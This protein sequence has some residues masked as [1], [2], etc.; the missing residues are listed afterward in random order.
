MSLSAGMF[1]TRFRSTPGFIMRGG[2]QP[3]VADDAR[4][5]WRASGMKILIGVILTVLA[6]F[7]QPALA[8]PGRDWRGGAM[9]AQMPRA[10]PGQFQRQP[11]QFQRQPQFE[12][13]PNRDFRRPEPPPQPPQRPGGRLTDVERRDLNRDLDRANREIYRR[14]QR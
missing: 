13:Q 5:I 6:A 2:M 1:L 10:Q 4:M 7:A 11:G 14:Q 8:G 12:R 9:P 3:D